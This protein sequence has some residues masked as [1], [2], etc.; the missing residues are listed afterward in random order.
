M[1]S[2]VIFLILSLPLVFLSW[3][4]FYNIRSHGLYRFLAW[5][6]ILWLL[7][8]NVSYWF[9][10]PLSIKQIISWVLLFLSLF[11][12]IASVWHL[13]KFGRSSR[14]R[15]GSELYTFEK[16]THLITQG[17]YQYIRHPMYSSL[18][19]LT[20]GIFFKNSNL[21]LLLISLLA[22]FLLFN[23]ARLEEHENISYFGSAY[24]DYMKK[25]RMFIPYFF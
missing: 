9:T 8:A 13:H 22:T 2:P 3:K 4:T 14:E 1:S 7:I 20:W 5:E 17:I 6:C 18:F 25:S 11:L 15:K 10:D 16:T 12:V 23:T 19:F 24:V 21:S